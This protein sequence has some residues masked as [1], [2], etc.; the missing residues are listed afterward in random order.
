MKKNPDL[1]AQKDDARQEGARSGRRSRVTRST[2]Q[3]IDKLE[4]I[5]PTSSAPRASTSIAASRSAARGC[6]ATAIS[7]TR[8]AE[9]RA[10][11][12]RGAQ[13]RLPGPRHAAR[14]RRRRSSSRSSTTARSIARRSGSR[15]CARCSCP[16]RIARGSRRCSA[17]RRARRSTRRSIDK[18]LDA[19]YKAPPLEDEKLRLD[20]LEKG[21][22]AQLKASK[23]PFMQAAQRIWPIYKAEEKKDDARDGRA[24]ARRSRST[25]RR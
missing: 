19:W 11:E 4:A 17:R 18:T 20:L 1:L 8:W 15:S 14:D 13:A 24:A 10:Q 21:T 2:R 25:S 9:E 5:S 6:S 16:R 22:P 3:A 23:D 7:L 12:G